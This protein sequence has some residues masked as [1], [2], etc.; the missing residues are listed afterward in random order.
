MAPRKRAACP[1][2]LGSVLKGVSKHLAATACSDL[3]FIPVMFSSYIVSEGM[4]MAL[5]EMS[6][7][8]GGSLHSLQHSGTHPNIRGR[9]LILGTR[10]DNL[11]CSPFSSVA[12]KIA[13]LMG[14]NS[15]DMLKALCFPRVKVGNEMVVKGQTV[16]QVILRC[17]HRI[18]STISKQPL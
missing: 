5:E 9:P 3:L 7:S 18:Q 6:F 11:L 16:Q 2:S 1:P 13:Y 12:D 15:A 4:M 14:L 8:G 10:N 17:V